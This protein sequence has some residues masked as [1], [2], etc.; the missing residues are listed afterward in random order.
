MR[1]LTA[2]QIKVLEENEWEIV[3]E[4]P[5]EMEFCS[6]FCGSATCKS[7]EEAYKLYLDI[8]QH[9]KIMKAL[10]AHKEKEK[11]NVSDKFVND[12]KG[13]VKE[14][15][16]VGITERT[17]LNFLNAGKDCMDHHGDTYIAEHYEE[18]FKEVFEEV[19]PS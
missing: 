10:N 12:L 4:S 9:K 1:V 19:D 8:M 11:K 13:T 18:F 16:T 2:E 5:F 15:L 17:L 7:T 3:C 14:L 6:Q